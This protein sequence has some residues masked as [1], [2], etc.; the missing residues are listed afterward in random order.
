MIYKIFFPLSHPSIY[1]YRY[2]FHDI[3]NILSHYIQ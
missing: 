1:L 3:L 2:L